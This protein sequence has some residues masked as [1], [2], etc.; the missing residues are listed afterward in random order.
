MVHAIVRWLEAFTSLAGK[1]TSTLVALLML[2]VVTTVVMSA[3]EINTVWAFATPL[4][5]VGA[6]ITLNTLLD[7]QWYLFAYFVMCGLAYTLLED[8]HVRVDFVSSALSP[9]ARA[10]LHLLGN[11]V[12]LF[13]FCVLMIKFSYAGTVQSFVTAEG[14][15][16]D[17]LGARWLVKLPLLLGFVLLALAGLADSLRQGMQLLSRE[18]MEPQP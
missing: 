4:P 3:F 10:A 7:M 14:S 16:Y 6:A 2:L 1:L 13:P 17:G 12:F 8:G 15:S 18:R 9:K 11:L 5:V